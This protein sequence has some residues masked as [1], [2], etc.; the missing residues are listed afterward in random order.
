M[1]IFLSHRSRDK[2]LVKDFKE[3]LP[4]FLSVW[5]DDE[6]LSWGDTLTTELRSTIQS[7]VDFLIVFLDKDSLSSEWVRQELDWAVERERQLKRVFVLPV[8]LP[9]AI[10]SEMPPVISNRLFLRLND[11]NHSSIEALAKKASEKLFKLVVESYACL[12]LEAPRRK[13]LRDLQD[14]LSAGQARLLGSVVQQ[15]STNGEVSQRK[16]EEGMGHSRTS[17]E[18]FYRLEAL[19]AQGF[20]AKRRIADDGMFSYQVTDEF[21]STFRET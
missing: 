18:L 7:G 16:I 4:P 21:E 11:Y 5:L 8:L 3:L 17:G 2:P 12:Q 19:I 20:L 15:C 6:S 13:S 1:K 10:P 14:G 9:D